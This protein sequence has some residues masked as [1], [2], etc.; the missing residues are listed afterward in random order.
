[1]KEGA[2]NIAIC[3]GFL[4]KHWINSTKLPQ[5]KPESRMFR[6]SPIII[7]PKM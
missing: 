3:C 6:E 1:M 7:A 2:R 4:D 5:G